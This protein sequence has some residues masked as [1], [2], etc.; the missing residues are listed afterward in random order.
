MEGVD[1]KGAL[2]SGTERESLPQEVSHL[3]DLTGTVTQNTTAV[4]LSPR[5]GEERRGYGIVEAATKD[6]KSTKTRPV[7]SRS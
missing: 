2:P 1:R 3:Q 5:R 4:S 6:P 7:N